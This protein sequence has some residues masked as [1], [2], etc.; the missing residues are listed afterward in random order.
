M[1]PEGG[2]GLIEGLLR[3]A[4]RKGKNPST[5]PVQ[6]MPGDAWANALTA[7]LEALPAEARAAWTGLLT[8]CSTATASAPARKWLDRA[9]VLVRAVG[10]ES[11]AEIAA[12]CLLQIGKPGTRPP[13]RRQYDEPTLIDESQADLVRGLVW[14]CSTLADE[15]LLAAVGAAGGP[16]SR[17]SP[18]TARGT[19]RS[20]TPASRP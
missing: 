19:S 4:S 5:A 1:M 9:A 13:V 8:H 10:E 16:A 6:L 17:R 3:E 12:R 7:D 15:R 11:F 18:I 20:A 14:S 2:D